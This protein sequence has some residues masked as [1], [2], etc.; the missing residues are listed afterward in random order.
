MAGDSIGKQVEGGQKRFVGP[1]RQKADTLHGEKK[2]GNNRLQSHRRK[3]FTKKMLCCVEPILWRH[4]EKRKKG[5]NAVVGCK[6]RRD[7]LEDANTVTGRKEMATVI[8]G[9]GES[10]VEKLVA[11]ELKKMCCGCVVPKKGSETT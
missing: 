7:E 1:I 4:K 9:Q 5:L 2:L 10:G 11:G 6:N 8:R 3:N